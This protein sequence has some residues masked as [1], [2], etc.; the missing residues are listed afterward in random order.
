[1]DY[2]Q[3]LQEEVASDPENPTLPKRWSSDNHSEC[4]CKLGQ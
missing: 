3:E 1:M 4:L 2:G